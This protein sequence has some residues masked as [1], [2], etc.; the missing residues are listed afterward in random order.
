MQSKTDS[1]FHTLSKVE[2]PPKMTREFVKKL[3]EKHHQ[4]LAINDFATYEYQIKSKGAN[5]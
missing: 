4:P 1:I 5:P 2:I 3:R